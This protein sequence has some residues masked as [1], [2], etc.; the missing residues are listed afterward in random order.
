MSRRLHSDA[1]RLLALQHTFGYDPDS[2]QLTCLPVR[3]PAPAETT[4]P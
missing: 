1:R 4:G 2:A 3:P